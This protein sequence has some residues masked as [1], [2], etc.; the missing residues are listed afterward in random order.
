MPVMANHQRRKLGLQ[1]SAVTENARKIGCGWRI[2][3]PTVR[4]M[5]TCCETATRFRWQEACFGAQGRGAQTIIAPGLLASAQHQ[6]AAV[7]R[8][9]RETAGRK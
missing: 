2:G 9:V 4:N 7:V 1:R 5:R 8:H 3:H 6:N